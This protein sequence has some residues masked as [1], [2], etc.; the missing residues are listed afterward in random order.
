MVN[1]TG[2][3]CSDGCQGCKVPCDRLDELPHVTFNLGGHNVTITG[4]DYTVKTD[5]TWPFCHYSV[6]CEL[7][8]GPDHSKSLERKTILLG[9]AFLRGIYSVYDFDARSVH[10][11]Q[12]LAR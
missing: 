6:R 12:S 8:I 9:S 7:L 1:L 5:I 3:D 2:A 10:C 11:R 4:E